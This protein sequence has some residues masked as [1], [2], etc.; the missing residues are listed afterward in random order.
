MLHSYLCH[1][2]T[3]WCT[4]LAKHAPL[5]SESLAYT[6]I[7]RALCTIWW[8]LKAWEFWIILRDVCSGNGTH[9]YALLASHSRKSKHVVKQ[10]SW[11]APCISVYNTNRN[12]NFLLPNLIFTQQE[13]IRIYSARFKMDM[14]L[15]F[16]QVLMTDVL[17]FTVFYKE[18]R[19][20]LWRPWWNV[21]VKR[22]YFLFILFYLCYPVFGAR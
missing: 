7:Q 14:P 18:N 17:I 2:Y 16:Q 20:I 5:D 4:W 3:I 13:E 15:H 10:S 11:L 21:H 12:V 19:E 6:P 8:P 9:G 1:G 22:L